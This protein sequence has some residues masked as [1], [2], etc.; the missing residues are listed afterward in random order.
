MDLETRNINGELSPYCISIFDGKISN[1]FYLSDYNNSE[2]MIEDGIKSLMRKKY[3]GYKIYLHNFSYFDGIFIIKI[4]SSLTDINL[5]PIIKDG[6]IINFPFI[7][8]T[9]FSKKN[10]FY[11]LEIPI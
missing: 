8:K 1:S 11:I 10:M 2:E 9:D 7:F 5:K 4:L 6:R 3:Y